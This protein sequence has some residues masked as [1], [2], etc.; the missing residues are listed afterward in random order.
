MTQIT[1]SGTPDEGLITFSGTPDEGLPLKWPKDGFK[2]G[3]DW[4]ESFIYMEIGTNSTGK[5]DGQRA[6]G[7]Q[8]TWKYEEHMKIGTKNTWKYEEK[9]Y[10]NMN[11]EHMKT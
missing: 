1:F 9:A 8:S 11:R 7:I 3:V 6:H 2:R 10:E 4:G 5:C